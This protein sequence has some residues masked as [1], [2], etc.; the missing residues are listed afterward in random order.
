LEILLP[1]AA[2]E[3]IERSVTHVDTN[4]YTYTWEL[5]RELFILAAM[6]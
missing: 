5:V 3:L 2:K 6:L 1:M 4:T